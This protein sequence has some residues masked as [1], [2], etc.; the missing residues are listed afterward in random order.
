MTSAAAVPEAAQVVALPQ[1]TAET[2]LSG[3]SED[4]PGKR[5]VDQR[6]QPHRADVVPDG[7]TDKEE[8]SLLALTS[9]EQAPRATEDMGSPADMVYALGHT[10][11]F[12]GRPTAHWRHPPGWHEWERYQ[13]SLPRSERY[14]DIGI[15]PVF[16]SSEPSNAEQ[17]YE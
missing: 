3:L 13:L 4:R 11:T 10:L 15:P 9:F 17:D 14:S 6:A 7:A 1:P 16:T 2:L 12:L 5:A 8:S